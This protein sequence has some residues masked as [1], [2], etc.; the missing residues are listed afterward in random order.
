MV[1]ATSYYFD[2]NRE[3]DGYASVG[4]GFKLAYMN[5]VGSLAFGSFIIALV[6]FIRVVVLTIAE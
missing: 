3:R 5:H 6:Q 4:L 1:S 2:S